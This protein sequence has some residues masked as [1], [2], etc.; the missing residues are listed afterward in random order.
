MTTTQAKSLRLRIN[1]LHTEL[2]EVNASDRTD[3]VK[4]AMSVSIRQSV[5]AA[6]F[7]L[8]ELGAR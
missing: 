6:E 5:R 2:A 4:A 1:S 3:F 8:T 7:E